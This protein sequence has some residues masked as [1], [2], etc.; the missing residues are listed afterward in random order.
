MRTGRE[1]RELRSVR[2]CLATVLTVL[3]TVLVPVGAVAA[4]ADLEIGNSDRFVSA[5]APLAS[6]PAVHEA[7]ADRITDG[8]MAQLDMG[9]LQDGVRSLLHEAVLSFATTEAFA[10]AWRTAAR[11]AHHAAVHVLTSGGGNVVTIDLAQITERVKGQLVHDHVPYADRIPVRHT[12]ITAVEAEG[13]GVWRDVAQALRAAG[14]WPALATVALSGVT[15][16]VAVRRRRALIGVGLG[17]AGG[18]MVLA[19]VV[20]VARGTLLQ[21]LPDNGDRGAARAIY[22]ALT[23]SLRTTAWSVLAGGLLLAL[24]AWLAGRP[25]R[26]RRPGGA[27]A[28][29]TP[30]PPDAPSAPGT[31][32]TSDAPAT[33]RTAGAPGPPGTPRTSSAPDTN[34]A[35]GTTGT[36]ETTRPAQPAD[37]PRLY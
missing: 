29:R 27:Q 13:L 35:A 12:Q 6:D 24:T 4:W 10:N 19:V 22:D 17:Y 32:R 21:D 34:G 25:R 23:A 30:E 26:P 3:L 31:A 28:R 20:A 33:A 36:T 9:P 37:P 14:V 1:S 16:L 5:M 7:V 18:A 2:A 15:V 8:V 11:A